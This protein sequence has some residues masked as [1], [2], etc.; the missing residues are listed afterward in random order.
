MKKIFEPI[1]D[2]VEETAQETTRAGTDTT[3]AIE[4][5]GE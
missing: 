2:S 1:T 3:K 5:N 4:L